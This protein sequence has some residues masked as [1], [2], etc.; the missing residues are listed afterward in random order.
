MTF[1]DRAQSKV[2]RKKW[3]RLY[4]AQVVSSER[5][6]HCNMELCVGITIKYGEGH[7]AADKIPYQ[8]S[9][10][11]CETAENRGYADPHGS[12]LCFTIILVYN[13]RNVS[14]KQV[15]F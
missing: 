7:R 10:R 8:K 9:K 12:S 14:L 4:K 13:S 6:R 2:Y 15:D 3:I 11:V 5:L 1:L